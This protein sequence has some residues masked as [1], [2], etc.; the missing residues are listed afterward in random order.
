MI[1]W[2]Q[3]ENIYVSHLKNVV[4]EEYGSPITKNLNN[5]KKIKLKISIVNDRLT[6]IIGK[7]LDCEKFN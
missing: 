1:Y 3:K 5:K 4:E 7:T 2:K 6:E